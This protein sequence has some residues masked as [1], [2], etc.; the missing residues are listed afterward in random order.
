MMLDVDFSICTDFRSRILESQD[1]ISKLRMG[2]VALVVPA[3]EFTDQRDGIDP[4]TFPKDK[5]V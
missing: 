5:E 4:S 3:F 2:D 1:V